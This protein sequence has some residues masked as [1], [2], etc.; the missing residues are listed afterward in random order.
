ML[1]A[2]LLNSFN[3][4]RSTIEFQPFL[5]ML[6]LGS[7]SGAQGAQASLKDPSWS[8]E[9]ELA[10][11]DPTN[12][13]GFHGIPSPEESLDLQKTC[14]DVFCFF[15]F[16]ECFSICLFSMCVF[17]SVEQIYNG[18]L[19]TSYRFLFLQLERSRNGQIRQNANL[20]WEDGGAHVDL[21]GLFHLYTWA[22][23]IARRA[24]VQVGAWGN[25]H[26]S[27]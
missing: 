10:S 3:S 6:E 15:L 9:S 18:I 8:R 25:V 26:L 21:D 14:F 13:I 24:S 20:I 5:S 11:W 12:S 27:S 1:R 2:V 23:Y 22:A 16:A 19:C 17:F 4:G 7:R